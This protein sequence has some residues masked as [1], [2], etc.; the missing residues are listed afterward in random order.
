MQM[1]KTCCYCTNSPNPYNY[2]SKLQ[3][4]CDTCYNIRCYQ[5]LEKKEVLTE[6]QI[7]S[8]PTTKFII[9]KDEADKKI[10][11]IANKRPGFFGPVVVT[12]IPVYSKLCTECLYN[13]LVTKPSSQNMSITNVIYYKYSSFINRLP[14]LG[15]DCGMNRLFKHI[16]DDYYNF[17]HN[18]I[19]HIDMIQSQPYLDQ[20][21]HL[22]NLETDTV[23]ISDDI[24]YKLDILLKKD[25]TILNIINEKYNE[26]ITNIKGNILNLQE[27][28]RHLLLAKEN[29]S[30]KYLLDSINNI[31]KTIKEYEFMLSHNQ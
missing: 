22:P 6:V 16:Y 9:A 21:V 28:K 29:G 20:E 2:N 25:D 31:D 30:N 10:K 19:K 5:C 7:E 1:P 15:G 4:I 8:L 23:E 12:L 17:K 18:V 24:K 13:D 14:N 27:A 26:Y 3:K 11:K